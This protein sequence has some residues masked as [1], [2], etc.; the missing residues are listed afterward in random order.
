MTIIQVSDARWLGEPEAIYRAA[1]E[2]NCQFEFPSSSEINPCCHVRI[3]DAIH[4]DAPLDRHEYLAPD[5]QWVA[6]MPAGELE[7]LTDAE[8]AAL[9]QA[10]GAQADRV[11]GS[12]DFGVALPPYCA[13]CG[14]ASAGKH[15]WEACTAP[16]DDEKRE[17]EAHVNKDPSVARDGCRYCARIVEWDDAVATATP[18]GRG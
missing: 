8:Y 1:R 9:T 18:A 4:I 16:S 5:E 6:R 3:D 7:W 15:D 2:D 11:T 10:F 12:A 14:P 13:W 17:H